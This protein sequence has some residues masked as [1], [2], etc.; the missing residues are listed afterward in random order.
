MPKFDIE[1]TVFRTVEA[2]NMDEAEAIAD[3]QKAMVLRLG[4]ADDL[5]WEGAATRIAQKTEKP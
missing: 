2:A 1:L 3:S 5:G 4:L